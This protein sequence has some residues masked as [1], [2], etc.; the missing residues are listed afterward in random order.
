MCKAGVGEAEGEGRR[1]SRLIK[2]G[3]LKFRKLTLLRARVKALLFIPV[4]LCAPLRLPP[5]GLGT[6]ELPGPEGHDN[7]LLWSP[8][9]GQSALP[10]DR[11][12]EEAETQGT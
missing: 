12:A 11:S 7:L 6:S 1:T 9:G 2:L 5:N 3:P 8:A 4:C 10:P